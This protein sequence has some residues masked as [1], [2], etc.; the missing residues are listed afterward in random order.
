MNLSNWTVRMTG[1]KANTNLWIFPSRIQGKH[2]QAKVE[3]SYSTRS[4]STL[5]LLWLLETWTLLSA[6]VGGVA[7]PLNHP[8]ILPQVMTVCQWLLR[9]RWEWELLE[10]VQHKPSVSLLWTNTN[11]SNSR[12]CWLW[13]TAKTNNHR[14]PWLQISWWDSDLLI[15]DR[16]FPRP[17]MFS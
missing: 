6:L 12:W 16:K 3:T 17:Q 2:V 13:H 10:H 1:N 8:Q 7:T 5:G 4:V 11:R 9:M 14:L 15:A